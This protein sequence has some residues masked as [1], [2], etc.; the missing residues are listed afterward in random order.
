[1]SEPREQ[2]LARLEAE[3]R[4]AREKLALYRA[5]RYSGRETSPVRMRELERRADQT[6]ERLEA[7]RRRA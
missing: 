1:V 5:K 3:A 6:A 7:A 4:L 2:E